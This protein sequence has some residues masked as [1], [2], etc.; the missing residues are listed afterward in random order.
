MM[1]IKILVLWCIMQEEKFVIKIWNF[2]K[3]FF[4]LAYQ[5]KDII[6]CLDSLYSI[7]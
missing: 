4:G 1:V 3:I 6:V 2:F 5:D 7:V